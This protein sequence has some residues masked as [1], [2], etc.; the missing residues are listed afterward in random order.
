MFIYYFHTVRNTDICFNSVGCIFMAHGDYS[1]RCRDF[2]LGIVKP[3]QMRIDYYFFVSRF[4]GF[5][6]EYPSAQKRRRAACPAVAKAVTALRAKEVSRIILTRPAV[7]A[8]EKLGFLP[9]DLQNK[10]DPYLRP[11]YDALYEMFG[12]ENFQRLSERGSI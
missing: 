6:S 5:Y 8:G 1:V 2:A 9:G 12:M 3:A 10:V 4:R 11:L 7:E